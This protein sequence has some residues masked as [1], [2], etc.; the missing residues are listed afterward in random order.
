[1]HRS[2]YTLLAILIMI[3]SNS[4][5]DLF[6]PVIPPAQ[7]TGSLAELTEDADILARFDINA[8]GI[9]DLIIRY[10]NSA[11]NYGEFLHNLL[12]SDGTGY[13]KGFIYDDYFTE[14]RF[15]NGKVIGYRRD[16]AAQPEKLVYVFQPES[17]TLQLAE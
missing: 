4:Q 12:I 6:S 16:D 2:R 9:D 17:K 1:M 7:L 14:L 11:S 13:Y 15:E 3:A 8:D 5:A 10:Q